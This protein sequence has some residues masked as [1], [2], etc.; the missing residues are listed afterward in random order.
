MRV[1]ALCLS[2]FFLIAGCALSPTPASLPTD[3]VIVPQG[4]WPPFATSA[5]PIPVGVTL[6]IDQGGHATLTNGS[7]QTL[8]LSPPQI[9][10]WQ[11]P[12]PWLEAD[13]AP[14]NRKLE[15]GAVVTQELGEPGPDQRAGVRLWDSEDTRESESNA[16]WFIWQ[17]LALASE[18]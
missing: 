16:P 5:A 15:P 12:S 4:D 18:S 2:M 7:D 1:K 3:G 17:P 14:G 6:T 11:G 10:I 13:V 9:E 8:W